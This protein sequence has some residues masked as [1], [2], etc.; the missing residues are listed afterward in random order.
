LPRNALYLLARPSTSD[1]V[2][3]EVE[4]MISAGEI[5]NAAVVKE[6]QA[7]LDR[8]EKA[9]VLADE[10]IAETEAKVSELRS[11][12]NATIS[13]E[14]ARLALDFIHY[15]VVKQPRNTTLFTTQYNVALRLAVRYG[16]SVRPMENTMTKTVTH[17]VAEL[18]DARA[19]NVRAFDEAEAAIETGDK[20]RAEAADRV[21][22]ETCA[23]EQTAFIALS[24]TPSANLREI[25]AE[26]RVLIDATTGPN[27]GEPIW[28]NDL[29][30]L[31]A[32]FERDIASLMR[33]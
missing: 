14:A 4:R 6:L 1:K 21:I 13:V 5:V 26:A 31:R 32:S 15:I 23:E 12:Q 28:E 10:A 20:T 8:T 16:S 27:L 3:E 25:V 7:K 30:A 17:I 19:R 18:A 33:G 2:R 29:P 24:V 22:T 11:A 9:K